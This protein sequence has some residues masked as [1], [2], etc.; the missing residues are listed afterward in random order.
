[1]DGNKNAFIEIFKSE[2]NGL[3][4]YGMKILP[5]K[6]GVEDGIQE[7]FSDLWSHSKKSEIKNIKGYLHASLKYHLLKKIKNSRSILHIQKNEDEYEFHIVTT[8]SI[9]ERETE[10]DQKMQIIQAMDQLSPRQREIVYL[11]F[12]QNLS[13]E[14][15]SEIMHINYQVSRNLLSRALKVLREYLILSSLICLSYGHLF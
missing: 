13:Y 8:S 15:I 1:M 3:F 2:Y 5:E 14:E 4:Q 12:M 6:Q 9:E 10:S 11:K 7:I